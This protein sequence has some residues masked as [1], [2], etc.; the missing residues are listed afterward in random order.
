MGGEG[1]TTTKAG[2]KI[3]DTGWGYDSQVIDFF[4][5]IAGFGFSPG[6]AEMLFVG[7]AGTFPPPALLFCAPCGTERGRVPS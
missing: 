6:D 3:V 4:G 7:N 5:E 1:E 2:G